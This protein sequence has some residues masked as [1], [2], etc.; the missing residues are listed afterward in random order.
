MSVPRE[1][2]TRSAT[3][4]QPAHLTSA[5]RSAPAL[6][7]LSAP[8]A[9]GSDTTPG[10]HTFSPLE[11]TDLCSMQTPRSQCTPDAESAFRRHVELRFASRSAT[12]L[13]RGQCARSADMDGDL[14]YRRAGL[15]RTER[16]V[17]HNWLSVVAVAC[18]TR[19]IWPQARGVDQPA[20]PAA[21]Q[22]PGRPALSRALVCGDGDVAVQAEA[23]RDRGVGAGR[24]RVLAVH[25]QA[26]AAG[27]T[28]PHGH[29]VG[30]GPGL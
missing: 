28:Q 30:E 4:R 13:V 15:E 20:A 17:M 27:I 22:I 3:P 26:D 16:A 14:G 8:K 7:R 29:G 10:C 25:R 12:E 23:E 18:R 24:Q 1:S 11:L 2:A 6:Q 21:E 5:R 9:P 19:R